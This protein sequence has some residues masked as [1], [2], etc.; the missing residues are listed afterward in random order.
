MQVSPFLWSNVWALSVYD[1]QGAHFF[2]NTLVEAL[3]LVHSYPLCTY[4]LL[5]IP[6]FF[7][8]SFLF[9]AG[10]PSPTTSSLPSARWL[11]AL[12]DW[13]SS[14]E[15]GRGPTSM[16]WNARVPF[17]ATSAPSCSLFCA[18]R[19]C[20]CVHAR[21]CACVCTCVCLP[22]WEIARA[23]I[24]CFSI[25]DTSPTKSGLSGNGVCTQLQ[26]FSPMLPF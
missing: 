4:P 2:S 12:G 21:M 22:Y 15:H 20:V 25:V 17:P 26:C 18:C 3:P 1:N 9:S 10:A 16:L 23:G 11:P 7:S 13:W 14:A 19:G 5:F 8:A 6:L 24:D